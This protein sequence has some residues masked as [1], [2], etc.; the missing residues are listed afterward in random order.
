MTPPP[1]VSLLALGSAFTSGA[2]LGCFPFLA[3]QVLRG[4]WP[5]L[6]D[7]DWLAGFVFVGLSLVALAVVVRAVFRRQRGAFFDASRMKGT[8]EEHGVAHLVDMPELVGL[9]RAAGIAALLGLAAGAWAGTRLH[10][11]RLDSLLEDGASW[12]A[13]ATVFGFSDETACSGAA[14]RCIREGW[15][16]PAARIARA[17]A[18]RSALQARVTSLR[19]SGASTGDLEWLVRRLEDS[20]E[21]PK[22]AQSRQAALVCLAE[23]GGSP[24]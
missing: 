18:L 9:A 17:G 16:L 4:E 24:F 12:C 14:E 19:A 13:S 3:V 6:E 11:S 1:N 5:P 23:S 10:R 22:G 15:A 20:S 7:K 21:S 8:P 2:L